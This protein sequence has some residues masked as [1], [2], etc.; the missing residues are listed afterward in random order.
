MPRY[1]KLRITGWELRAYFG[2]GSTRPGWW[3]YFATVN[4][5]WYKALYFGPVS[6]IL[7]RA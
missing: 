2:L 7:E 1:F 5:K 6:I 4:S 3:H